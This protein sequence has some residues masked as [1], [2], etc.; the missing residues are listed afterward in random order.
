MTVDAKNAWASIKSQRNRNAT[1]AWT[2]AGPSTAN[3]PAILTFSGA[4]YTTSGRVTALAIDPAC[5]NRRCTVWVGAAGGGVWRTDNALSGSGAKW[6]FVSESFATNAIGTLTFDSS[7][8]TLYAG[9]GEPNASG[10][11]EAGFGIYKSTDR[12]DTWVQLA[13]NTSV[14]LMPTT[15]GD[16]P[17]YNGPAFNGRAIGSIVVSGT[18]MYVGSTRAV[19]GVSSVTGG[20]V[21]IAPGLPPFGLWKSTDGGANFTLLNAEG[22]CL[23]PALPGDA[24]KIQSSFG[25]VRGVHHIEFDPNYATQLYSLRR[26]V[27]GY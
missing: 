15:C 17:A 7:T 8:G 11:S 20:G 18:T 26:P 27:S 9:T 24:G 6:T 23:N 19:R 3:F 22:I 4:A 5:T 13:A 1:G 14:P 2:L 10:D 12:G 25:S 21:S 16:A